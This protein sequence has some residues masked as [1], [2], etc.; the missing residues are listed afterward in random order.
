MRDDP[1]AFTMPAAGRIFL[2]RLSW[3]KPLL[4]AVRKF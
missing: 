2:V 3:R 4:E 1:N